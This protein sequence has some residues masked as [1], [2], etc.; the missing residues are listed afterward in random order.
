MPEWVGKTVKLHGWCSKGEGNLWSP[1]SLPQ[2]GQAWRWKAGLLCPQHCSR[3][4]KW[5][6]FCLR[7]VLCVQVQVLSSSVP[8]EPPSQLPRASKP[9]HDHIQ[10]KSLLTPRYPSRKPEEQAWTQAL[11]P[12]KRPAVSVGSHLWVYGTASVG[13][14]ALHPWAM[15][16]CLPMGGPSHQGKKLYLRVEAPPYV[17]LLLF[18]WGPSLRAGPP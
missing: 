3:C 1:T 2:R 15:G 4:K 16:P 13:T 5:F 8:T 9:T 12:V 7:F 10:G 6:W 11:V 18:P 14:R 17:T